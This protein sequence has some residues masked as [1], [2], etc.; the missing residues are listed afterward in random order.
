MTKEQLA[1][2][3]E[4]TIRADI[5]KSGR[6]KLASFEEFSREHGGQAASDRQQGRG[7]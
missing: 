5:Q 6:V 2:L 3:T 4:S 1:E 7:L